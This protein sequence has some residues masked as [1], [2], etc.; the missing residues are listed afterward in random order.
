[1][2]P[3]KCEANLTQYFKQQGKTAPS[4]LHL[5][6]L[7]VTCGTLVLVDLIKYLIFLLNHPKKSSKNNKTKIWRKKGKLAKEK[8]KG[9]ADHI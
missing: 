6:P 3:T 8:E 2:W 1:L 9:K 5:P 7:V 4:P